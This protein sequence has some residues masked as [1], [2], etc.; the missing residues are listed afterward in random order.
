MVVVNDVESMAACVGTTTWT[1]VVVV[2]AMP[3]SP[4]L[5]WVIVVV[6]ATLPLVIV[7]V[8][9]VAHNGSAAFKQVVRSGVMTLLS[10]LPEK[11][12]DAA[13]FPK[14]PRAV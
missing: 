3:S 14:K 7:V 12:A 4:P 13:L 10:T 5:V 9:K 1:K 11:Q 2:A 6:K 8:V